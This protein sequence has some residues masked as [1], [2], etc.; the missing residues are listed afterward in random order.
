VPAARRVAQL[1]R[2]LSRRACAG[3][4]VVKVG[5]EFD[6]RFA[7]LRETTPQRGFNNP[8]VCAHALR[9][10]VKFATCPGSFTNP[11]VDMCS[12][13]LRRGVAWRLIDE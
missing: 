13:T 3:R 10:A 4:Q 5:A 9:T 12:I 1:R 7:V 6:A 11:R 8:S 2:K